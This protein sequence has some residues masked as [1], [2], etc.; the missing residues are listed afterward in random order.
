MAAGMC[1][2]TAGVE[3][4]GVAPP[5]L[6][7]TAAR[8][9]AKPP[10][11]KATTMAKSATNATTLPT[12]MPAM[13]LGAS[14]LLGALQP[15]HVPLSE[16]E[17]VPDGVSGGDGV[18]ELDS[19]A[20][21]LLL[22]VCELDGV[23]DGV[24]DDVA[25][26]DGVAVG[27]AD[28]LDVA[29]ADGVTDGVCEAV[30]VTL[31]E[32]LGEGV[33]GGVSNAEGELLGV[34]PSSEA[35][36]VA[37]GEPATVGVTLD[38]SGSDSVGDA[39]GV[40]VADDPSV[41]V[42]DGVDALLG[43]TLGVAL[44]VD[45]GDTVP[46]GVGDPDP[47]V[48][49]PSDAREDTVAQREGVGES[50]VDSDAVGDTAGSGV[51]CDTRRNVLPPLSAMK[52]SP[53]TNTLLMGALSV[54]ALPA[55]FAAPAVPFPTSVVTASVAMSKPRSALFDVS[56]TMSPAAPKATPLGLKKAAAGPTPSVKPFT[57]W[58]ASVETMPAGSTRRRR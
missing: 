50:V 21:A 9:A 31:G 52:R 2:V 34:P 48:L 36:G 41:A 47:V 29:D 26:A 4:R 40:P 8:A 6:R 37:D 19:D 58:P 12:T 15:T 17:G 55:P 5:P 24:P 42:V 30:G 20:D 28:E 53:P 46:V 54:A 44:A 23:T 13:A 3:E 7:C 35:D 56:L 45:V 25:V 10:K 39:L 11:L 16:R 14:A 1:T 33:C 51:V 32:P 22:G 38:V 57:S 27:D 43:V 49:A 18:C